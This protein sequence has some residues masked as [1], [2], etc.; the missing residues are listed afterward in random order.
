[1]NHS[2]D[3]WALRNQ[4]TAELRELW[5]QNYTGEGMWGEG[6]LLDTGAFARENLELEL[7]EE[8]PGHSKSYQQ[9]FTSPHQ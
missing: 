5:E 1:M 3:F 9:T 4:Y 8:F 7:G 6:I 2:K